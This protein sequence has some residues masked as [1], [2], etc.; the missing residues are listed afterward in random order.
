MVVGV[1]GFV[2]DVALFVL[3]GEVVFCEGLGGG[4]RERTFIL[5]FM[6]L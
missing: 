6:G 4:R 3:A 5:G 1:P 2:D